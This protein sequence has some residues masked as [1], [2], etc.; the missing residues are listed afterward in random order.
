M[1]RYDYQRTSPPPSPWVGMVLFAGV[2]LLLTGG[3]EVLEGVVML[4]RDDLAQATADA[5]AIPLNFTFWAWAQLILGTI[6]VLTGIGVLYG[7]MWAR[8]IAIM[9]GVVSAF[10]NMIM[11]PAYPFWCSIVI[12]LDVLC[13]YAVAAHGREIRA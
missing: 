11:L 4:A 2:T 9:I 3:F 8:I 1:S 6:S 10:T 12:A 7:R 13:I 5:L